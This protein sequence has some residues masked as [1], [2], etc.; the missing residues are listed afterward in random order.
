VG[1]AVGAGACVGAG[2]GVG[3]LQRWKKVG[4]QKE[5]DEADAEGDCDEIPE[6]EAGRT[7]IKLQ[8]VKTATSSAKSFL[9]REAG[10]LLL[11]IK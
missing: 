4:I 6:A 3:V 9:V 1:V 2:V 10:V 8:R 11:F 5:G 7:M